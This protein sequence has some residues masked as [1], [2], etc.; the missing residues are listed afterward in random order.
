MVFYSVSGKNAEVLKKVNLKYG[1]GIVGNVIEKNK[2]EIVNN[3][4]S[5]ERFCKRVDKE[6][7]FYTKNILCVPMKTK[8]KIIGAIEVVNKIDKKGFSNFDL[9]MCEAIASISSFA[10]ERSKL[11]EE[12]IK[13]V[14]LA[15]IGQAV[16]GIAHCVK[17]ILNGLKGGE[18]IV[19]RG[20]K[21]N[22]YKSVQ[23]GWNMVEKNIKKVSTLVLDML[24]Y[25]KERKPEYE[26]IELEKTMA[27]VKE[28]YEVEANKL[29]V[30]IEIN[31][32][33]K[34]GKVEIDPKGIYRCLVNLVGNGIDACSENGGKITMESRYYDENYF[35]INVKDTGCGMDQ[36]A[37]QNLFLKF[38][39]TKGSKGTGLGLPVTNKIIKEHKGSIEVESVLGKGTTFKIKL[40]KYQLRK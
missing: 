2:S 23:D 40:P 3:P 22:D 8:D 20:M 1:E 28:L 38:F 17:N 34:I 29:G 6:T 31:S 14:K 33:D 7:G 35:Y 13:V 30:S 10:I 27:E 15:G 19:N 32:D 16:A 9:L 11:I 12:N 5:D 37:L 21:I 18:Y 26:L 39:S 24:Y 4:E 25:S 36:N